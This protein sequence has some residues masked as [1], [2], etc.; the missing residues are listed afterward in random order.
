MDA[1]QTG[2]AEAGKTKTAAEVGWYVSRY[3]LI[4]DIPG[5]NMTA[6]FNTRTRSCASLESIRA[7]RIAAIPRH[8]SSRCMGASERNNESNPRTHALGF[9]SRCPLR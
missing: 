4:A 7:R 6:I 3:N 5:T 2:N 8:S 1:R 9:G